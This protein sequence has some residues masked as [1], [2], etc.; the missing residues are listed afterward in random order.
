MRLARRPEPKK[1]T[2]KTML[3]AELDTVLGSRPE[4]HVVTVADGAHDNG[5]YLDALAPGA[6]SVVDFYQYAEFRIMPR[7]VLN[8]LIPFASCLV[9][10][11]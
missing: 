6:T 3:S 10:S 2:L 4:L 7:V 9:F 1:A 8:W 11:A 5:R